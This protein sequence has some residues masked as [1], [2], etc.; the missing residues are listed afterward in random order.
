[1]DQVDCVNLHLNM[2]DQELDSLSI[3]NEFKTQV[4]RL[5][6]VMAQDG[7][8]VRPFLPGLPYFSRLSFE[9]QHLA[10]KAVEFYI[11]LCSEHISAG[12]K[13]TDSL[14]FTWRALRK[15]G[16]RPH[17]DLFNHIQEDD[18]I[19][20]YNRDSRQLYRNFRYYDFC[21]YSFEEL[22][23][24]EWWNL[25]DRD[26]KITD[27]LLQEGIKVFSGEVAGYCLSATPKHIVR[28]LISV[29]RLANAYQAK[30][31]APLYEGN[32]IEALLVTLS[33][34]SVCS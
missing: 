10:L 13:L 21:S 32:N 8:Y 14:S 29:D 3:Q 24:L 23:S 12:E 26:Q 11:D 34:E 5:S 28:E 2:Q 4:A 19:E 31:I 7:I 16:L 30:I 20:I 27:A 22:Y 9:A 33:A 25:F 18:M 1:M 17:S 15:L 6:A